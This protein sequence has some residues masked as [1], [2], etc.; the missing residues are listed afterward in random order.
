MTLLGGFGVVFGG[1]HAVGAD[2]DTIFYGDAPEGKE[3]APEVDETV[4]AEAGAATI[5]DVEWGEDA[6]RVGDVTPRDC[7]QV[8][9]HFC[10]VVPAGVHLRCQFHGVLYVGIQLVAAYIVLSSGFVVHNDVQ[11]FIFISNPST[12]PVP[13]ASFRCVGSLIWPMGV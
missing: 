4:V 5:I 1:K 9:A 2:K 7:A 13:S 11:L 12:E 3:C 8:L 6:H 10:L